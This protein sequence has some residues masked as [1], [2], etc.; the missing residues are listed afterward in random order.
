MIRTR[1]EIYSALFGLLKSSA[2]FALAS[3]TLIS[4]DDIA[5]EQCPALFMVQDGEA[6]DQ[7]GVGLPAILN[8]SVQALLYVNNGGD[9]R[10]LNVPQINALVDA[11]CDAIEPVQG[12][13]YQT[14][15]LPDVVKHCWVEGEIVYDVG[16]LGD[17]GVAIVPIKLQV[18]GYSGKRRAQ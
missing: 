15:G 5:R 10:D 12:A 9:H 7:K 17:T 11:V 1:E 16:Y 14:L 3:R 18:A 13:K 6:I 8:I 4:W 2:G